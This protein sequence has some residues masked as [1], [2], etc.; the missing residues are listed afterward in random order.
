[1]TELKGKGVSGGIAIG[2][3]SFVGDSEVKV[4]RV[5]TEDTEA[6]L[7]RFS[8][9]KSKTLEQLSKLYDKAV[10]E[11]GETN[12][13]I[14]S[15]HQMMVED[16]DYLDS[17]KNIIT[18]QKVNAEYAV[19]VTGDNFA[20]MFS[21]MDDEY[22]KARASDV[23]DI[24]DRLI[25][26][27]M[28][29]SEVSDISDEE[30]KLI[31]CADDLTPSETVQMDK[32]KVLAFVTRKGSSNSHTA[33]LARTLGIP[34]VIGAGD[35]LSEDFSGRPAAVNAFT[36]EIIIEPDKNTLEKMR[37]LQEEDKRRKELIRQ[38]KG[39]ENITLDGKRIKLYANIG[40]L[41]DAGA[42]LAND[43]G[44][45]GLFRSE[46]LYLENS[47][48]PTEE[49]Q[50]SV[51][52]T[53]AESMAGRPVIIRTMDIGA[54]K[55]I[56]YFDMPTEENPA[57]GWRAL[58]VCLDREEIFR[59]QLRALC[60]A[61][62][63]GNIM[64]MLPM[65]ASVWEIRESKRIIKDIQRE[66]EE[67][68]IDFNKNM[69]VGIMIET[70]SAAVISDIL[71]KEVDFFSIGTNDLT[72]YTLA[73][74][75]QNSRLD[76]FYDP[77]HTSVLRLIDMTVKNAHANG[78]WCGICGELGGDPEMTEAFLAMGVDELSMAPSRILEIRKK[79]RET[80]ISLLDKEKLINR[81]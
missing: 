61:S 65:V 60:R 14:F 9:S 66:L 58:R 21:S 75:R 3:L 13:Q 15:I 35:K 36:G 73:V 38:Q 4:R 10:E 31:I 22:M 37:Q 69:Q 63:F 26:N 34:A 30:E 59:T 52:K 44:G 7:K 45:I 70:P 55:Q 43:A 53:A 23:K 28:P 62:A 19:A 42:A 74:D 71:A 77:Y 33:I 17:I 51:Y 48:Y 78:I 2:R 25:R 16:M 80:D 8:Q 12:A 20:A 47:S 39:K 68:G 1:M 67:Q 56:D 72:Q 49:Q 54:D 24:S 76:R 57:M 18:S 81:E 41:G 50:F 79:V 46:F 5:R 32:S 29:G 6:E 27:L 11:V 64:I 40:G